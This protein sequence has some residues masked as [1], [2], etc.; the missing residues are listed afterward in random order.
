[1]EPTPPFDPAEAKERARRAMENADRFFATDDSEEVDRIVG[2]G[3]PVMGW[4]LIRYCISRGAWLGVLVG[5]VDAIYLAVGLKVPMTSLQFLLLSGISV[6]CFGILGVVL[7]GVLGVPLSRLMKQRRTSTFAAVHFSTV[8]FL[9]FGAFFWTYSIGVLNEGRFIPAIVLSG[10]PVVLWAVLWMNAAPRFRRVELGRS[11]PAPWWVVS[12]SVTLMILVASTLTFQSRATSGSDVL[13]SDPNVVLITVEGLRHDVL[14]FELDPKFRALMTQST[15]FNTVLS[16][17]RG[18]RSANASILSGLHPFH[19]DVVSEQSPLKATIE[20]L[21]RVMKREGFATAAFISSPSLNQSSGFSTGFYIYDDSLDGSMSGFD[22]IWAATL[23]FWP[24][25]TSVR[26]H[27]S[28]EERFRFWLQQHD[29][30]PFLSWIQLSDVDRSEV[31][32]REA[33]Q[34]WL[35]ELGRSVLGIVDTLSAEQEWNNTLFV[36]V[37]TSGQMLGEQ[38]RFS[39]AAGLFDEVVR[40]PL[41]VRY[42]KGV[43]SGETVSEQVRNYDIYPTLLEHLDLIALTE[44]EGSALNGYLRG[45]MT[46]SMWCVLVGDSPFESGGAMLG[47]RHQGFKYQVDINTGEEWL[48]DV[49]EDPGESENL[50]TRQTELLEQ[51]RGIVAPDRKRV[52]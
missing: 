1:M 44:H 17:S 43:H 16:P 39:G 49:G 35:N 42:P 40:V 50:V 46:G 28:V 48:F 38:V 29:G 20:T 13:E 8:G 34:Q 41:F 33:Y 23:P 26:S 52:Q 25:R 7:G 4:P 21:P 24:K 37:G 18:A 10:L 9:L 47:L 27:S 32:T 14:S 5:S 3:L 22:K 19:H 51:V 31:R 30:A 2:D 15:H 36:L 6:S 45:E 11:N 12:A